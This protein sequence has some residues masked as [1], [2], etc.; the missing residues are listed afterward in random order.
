MEEIV[1]I[2]I[3][4]SDMNGIS[5]GGPKGSAS[6]GGGIGSGFVGKM[7][8]MMSG[9]L[10]TLG[11]GS[12]IGIVVMI[13]GSFKSLLNLVSNIIKVIS[14]ILKPIADVVMILLM[15]ILMILKPIMQIANQ[16]M[17]PFIK[18]SMQVMREGMKMMA[19]G[20]VAGGAS[21]MLGAGAIAMQGFNSVII[22][23]LGGVMNVLIDIITQAS[24]LLMNSMV[25]ILFGMFG[26]ILSMF[27]VDVGAAYT[28]I[29]TQINE[30]MAMGNQFMKDGVA[31]IMGNAMVML[32]SNA[33]IIAEGFGVNSESF[34]ASAAKNIEKIF[35]ESKLGKTW[36][37]KIGM[38]TGFGAL[39]AQSMRNVMG[40]GG[41]SG[42]FDDAMQTFGTEGKEATVTALAGIKDTFIKTIQDIAK[43]IGSFGIYKSETFNKEET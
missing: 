6:S 15:P 30:N 21:A 3:I 11:I 35:G 12:L 9:V 28:S 16:I 4:G 37:D 14:M 1:A 39:A 23:L 13:V 41:L 19:S 34:Q 38:V 25:N 32:A 29:T 18:L 43:E 17:A 26:G 7:G 5:S 27:G 10:K 2:K 8:G 42:T 20:D 36:E 31:L 40:E 33:A 24:S 22:G